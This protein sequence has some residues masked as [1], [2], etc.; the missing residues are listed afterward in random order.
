MDSGHVTAIT[1]HRGHKKGES[2]AAA[3]ATAAAVTCCHNDQCDSKPTR[4]S[5]A[6]TDKVVGSVDLVDVAVPAHVYTCCGVHAR[7]TRIGPAT[8][9]WHWG[10]ARASVFEFLCVHVLSR[11]VDINQ[12]LSAHFAGSG[13]T[14]VDQLISFS[15]QLCACGVSGRTLSDVQLGCLQST[16]RRVGIRHVGSH[17]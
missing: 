7:L 15:T 12:S 5:G 3:T 13:N 11:S 17:R 14:N 10:A 1:C 8:R 4:Y 2:T 16:M 6:A 9:A